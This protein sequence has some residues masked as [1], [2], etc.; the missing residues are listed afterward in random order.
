MK[1][2]I[3][4]EILKNIALKIDLQK[5]SKILRL[6]HT[7]DSQL[8]EDLIDK[9][10]TCIAPK[11]AYKLCYI[12]EKLDDAVMVEGLQLKSKVLRP[13]LAAASQKVSAFLRSLSNPR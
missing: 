1:G 2:F 6:E 10:K 4:V 3:A 13:C 9:A 7:G 11:A 12:D 8:V 5:V